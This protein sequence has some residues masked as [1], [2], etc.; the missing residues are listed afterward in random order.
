MKA[1][2]SLYGSGLSYNEMLFNG[3]GTPWRSRYIIIHGK[4]KQVELIKGV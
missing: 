2:R 4:F 1:S 3:Q